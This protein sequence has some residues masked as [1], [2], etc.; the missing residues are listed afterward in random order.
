MVQIFPLN[1][2]CSPLWVKHSLALWSRKALA[3]SW[4]WSDSPRVAH[5]VLIDDYTS[6]QVSSNLTTL[7]PL[8][9]TAFNNHL[10]S[11]TFICLCLFYSHVICHLLCFIAVS[12]LDVS[13]SL[14]APAPPQFCHLVS[15]SI[16][17]MCITPFAHLKP[18]LF[19]HRQLD[20]CIHRPLFFW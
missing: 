6:C 3:G 1:P 16:C 2:D 15:P 7:F 10:H 11:V 20:I 8:H 4:H 12:F 18:F 17:D 13:L 19:T 5:R 14:H 9:Y